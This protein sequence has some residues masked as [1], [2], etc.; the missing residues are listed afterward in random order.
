[1]ANVLFAGFL[2][3]DTG[4]AV[5]SATVN[6]YA[7]NTT[8]PSL[9][10]TT[11][12]ANGYWAISHATQGRFDIEITSGTVKRRIKYDDSV[13]LETI[14]TAV[15]RIRN[16]ADTFEYDIV[17]GAIT[18]ARQ[19]NLPVITTTDEVAVLALAQTF[20]GVKTFSAIPV[21]SGGA[22][23]FPATQ[24]ASADANDFDDY[25]EEA[26]T[27]AVTFGGA[28]VGMTFSSQV[29]TA[30][31]KGREISFTARLFLSAKGSSTGDAVVTGLP[32]AAN[33]AQSFPCTLYLV[34]G[35]TFADV[36]QALLTGG[37]T[38]IALTEVTKAGVVTTLTNADFTDTSQFEISGTYIV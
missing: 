33:A 3:D 36:P 17:P 6:L 20:S 9:A 24:V 22:I 4:A 35:I 7:R 38:T 31:K 32:V 30:T 12:D 2:Y 23:H 28:A 27:P 5:A 37:G 11:T 15:F 1:M 34:Q 8:T 19:L 26:F 10:N 16:P 18:A 29:G 21:M 25:Q 13:Q 14:E